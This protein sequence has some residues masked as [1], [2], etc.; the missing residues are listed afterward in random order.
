MEAAVFRPA[1]RNVLFALLAGAARRGARRG[2]LAAIP[3]LLS[4]LFGAVA[5]A[6]AVGLRQLTGVRA[7]ATAK[8]SP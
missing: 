8:G 7:V 4:L 3:F 5:A 1:L 2:R 6:L